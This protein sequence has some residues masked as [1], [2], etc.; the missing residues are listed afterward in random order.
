MLGEKTRGEGELW[1]HDS[2]LLSSSRNRKIG[3]Q[4]C[5]VP[6]VSLEEIAPQSSIDVLKIDI[7]GAE[8]GLVQTIQAF[9]K[10]TRILLIELH[11]NDLAKIKKIK[12]EFVN[13]GLT[14]FG[15]EIIHGEHRLV[16]YVRNQ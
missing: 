6:W 7:E 15:D 5:R 14:Q 11:P 3:H 9:L 10:R 8:Y 12:M 13:A 16:A 4:V 1:T 2:N